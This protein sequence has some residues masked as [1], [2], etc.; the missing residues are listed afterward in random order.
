MGEK[1]LGTHEETV[2]NT[3]AVVAIIYCKYILDD[4]CKKG[5]K[6]KKDTEIGDQCSGLKEGMIVGTAEIQTER[7]S[8]LSKKVG[9]D[10]GTTGGS[11]G[12]Y[13]YGEATPYQQR[14]AH[15]PSVA[16]GDHLPGGHCHTCNGV[17]DCNVWN[18]GRCPPISFESNVSH[19][20]SERYLTSIQ[21]NEARR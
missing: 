8:G 16:F 4:C 21:S 6:L 17:V 20:E 2:I 7:D 3:V 10:E 12:G 15:L 11:L 14:M 18:L 5:I 9:E 1:Q 13:R 19:F